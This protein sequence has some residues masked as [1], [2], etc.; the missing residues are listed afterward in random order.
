MSGIHAT[1]AGVVLALFIPLKQS[2]Q[3]HKTP[4]LE[5]L[6]HLL[7]TPVNFLVLPLFALANTAL[8]I[9]ADVAS[10]LTHPLMLGVM[11]GLC[12]GK[13]IGIALFSWLAI[14]F[15]LASIPQGSNWKQLFAAGILGGIGFT[16]SIFISMLA[17]TQPEYQDLARI[18]ILISSTVAGLVGYA[19]MKT[20][21]AN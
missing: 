1:I 7:H 13:P 10:R 19:L 11:V 8:A 21:V 9:N 4:P 16:M 5:Y 3:E 18:A 12:I 20:A 2:K 6:E 14:R 17:F 15:N